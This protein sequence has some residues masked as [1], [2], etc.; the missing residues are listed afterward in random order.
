MP[1]ATSVTAPAAIKMMEDLPGVHDW[2]VKQI[3]ALQQELGIAGEDSIVLSE[4]LTLVFTSKDFFGDM[5]LP[6]QYKFVGPVFN[7]RT[8]VPSFNWEKLYQ[9][10]TQPRILVSIGTTF[11]HAYKKEF[12]GKVIEALGDEPI[13]VIVVSDE[14][15]FDSWPSNFLVQSRVPQLDLL[16]H[17]DGVVCHGGHNTV[18]ETLSHGIPLVVIPIAYDQSHVAGQV[19]QAASG[20]RLNYKRFKAVHLK[21]AVWQI[22]K[23]PAYKHAAQRIQ[24]SF[25][26]SGGAATAAKLLE[27]LAP[28]VPAF[29]RITNY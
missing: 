27:S 18:C 28:V 16:P 25:E 2:E 17:L 13:S 7:N 12:F 20:I 11:D 29:H 15:L 9:L 23:E 4:K 19:I 24:D 5:S 6:S 22:L 10:G 3:V 14:S 8:A 21:E 1:Y 26:R